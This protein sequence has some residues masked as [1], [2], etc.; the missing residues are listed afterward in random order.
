VEQ[1][2]HSRSEELSLQEL[3]DVLDKRKWLIL[4]ITLACAAGALGWSMLQKPVYQTMTTML[5]EKEAPRVVALNEVYQAQTSDISEYE[6]QIRIISSISTA[7]KVLSKLEEQGNYHLSESNQDRNLS[8]LYL[9]RSVKV[10]QVPGSRLIKITHENIN[11]EDAAQVCNLYV[12]TYIEQNMELKTK[13]S[14]FAISWLQEQSDIQRE[15]LRQSELSLQQYIDENKITDIPSIEHENQLLATLR[16]TEL[17]IKSELMSSSLKYKDK[18]PKM[19]EL[20]TRLETIQKQIAE[21]T[22]KVLK[23]NQVS[24]QYNILKREVESNRG[25]YNTLIGRLKE[26]ML[27]DELMLSNIKVL[28]PAIVPH[29]P[30]KPKKRLNTTVGF[31][32]GLLLGIGLAF[33]IELFEDRVET[34]EDVT[35]G[36]R[37]T[38]VATVPSSKREVKDKRTSDLIVHKKPH[39]NVAEAYR[40]ART[41]IIRL[42]SEGKKENKSIIVTSSLAQEG[43][44]TVSVNLSIVFAQA[45]LNV[46]LMELDLRRPRMH[47]TFNLNTPVGVA[48]YLQGT[49]GFEDIVKQTEIPN[50]SIA[51][52]GKI[53]DHPSELVESYKMDELLAV[54]VKNYDYVFVDTPPVL[55]V[56]DTMIMGSKVSY[57][58]QVIKSGME[59]KATSIMSKNKLLDTKAHYLGVILNHVEPQSDRYYYYYYY[60]SKD[61]DDKDA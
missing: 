37:S 33:A 59:G 12:E 36:L 43:K 9:S 16:S 22:D 2:Q 38:L 14:K 55:N 1:Q 51:L 30:V 52:C 50:L 54:A 56:A 17:G 18:H 34:A 21:E 60:R 44:T 23:M 8:A 48:Q 6:T 47:H 40:I 25:I 26:T 29:K 19:I 42:V 53:P 49:A 13:A 11:P 4:I 20:S 58:V 39:S 45:G 24:M 10:T 3:L 5:L 32:A 35:F 61:K 15:K 28:D 27:S 46:L 41:E 7:E 57:I 31:I